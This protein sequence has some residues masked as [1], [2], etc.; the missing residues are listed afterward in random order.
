MREYDTEKEGQSIDVMRCWEC[1]IIAGAAARE[2]PE[3]GKRHA[4]S[5][6]AMHVGK[7]LPRKLASSLIKSRQFV[8]DCSARVYMYNRLCFRIVNFIHGTTPYLCFFIA[9][10]LRLIIHVHSQQSSSRPRRALCAYA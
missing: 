2:T 6:G 10:R 4:L 8:F 9:C 7:P 3:I 5:R 1:V